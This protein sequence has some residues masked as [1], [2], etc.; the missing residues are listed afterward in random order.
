MYTKE[1]KSGFLALETSLIAACL[2]TLN[3][4]NI[5]LIYILCSVDLHK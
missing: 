4:S 1:E 3:T 2:I 5:I